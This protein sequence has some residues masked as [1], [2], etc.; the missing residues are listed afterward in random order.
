MTPDGVYI[1]IECSTKSPHQ[2]PHFVEDTLFLQ[3]IYYQTYVNGMVVSFHENKK[4]IWPPFT[5]STKV[6]KIENFKQDK[7]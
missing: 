1:R 7:D 6:C 4:S 2:L 3:E 5:L